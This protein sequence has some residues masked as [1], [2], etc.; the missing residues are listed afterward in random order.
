MIVQERI[1]PE[2]QG[3]WV[4]IKT[5]SDRGVMIRQ[6]ETGDL[7]AEAVDPDF[8]NRTYTETN[9]PIDDG[10][11]EQEDTAEHLLNIILGENDDGN[12]D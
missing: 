1:E 2:Q 3:G 6:D 4:L 12:S 11:D 7:Y 5:Y 10:D 9:I 8:A